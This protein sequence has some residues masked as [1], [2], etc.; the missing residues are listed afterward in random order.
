MHLKKIGKLLKCKKLNNPYS[1]NRDLFSK[2]LNLTFSGK[3][4]VPFFGICEVLISTKSHKNLLHQFEETSDKW[5]ADHLR[6]SKKH[7]TLTF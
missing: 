3:L 6:K 1:G 5:T 7:F 4:V 2:I